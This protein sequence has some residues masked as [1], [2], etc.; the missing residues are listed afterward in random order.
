MQSGIP[1]GLLRHEVSLDSYFFL[2]HALFLPRPPKVSRH[3]RQARRVKTTAAA[4][5]KTWACQ[6]GRGAVGEPA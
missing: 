5:L 2:M 1:S 4:L 6:S 3:S